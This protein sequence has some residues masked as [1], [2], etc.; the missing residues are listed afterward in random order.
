MSNSTHS[1]S[2]RRTTDANP[3]E[4]ESDC[5]K[6]LNLAAYKF[7][8]LDNLHERRRQLRRMA[9]DLKLCGTILITPEGINLF[10]AGERE[11]AECFLE[12]LRSEACFVDLSVKKSWTSFQPFRRM[13]VKIKREIIA[14]GIDSVRPEQKTSPKLS[15]E[16][17]K[18]WLDA[19][20]E[21]TLLDTRNDYEVEIG[22]FQGAL[23][24]GL[25]HFRDF[26]DAAQSLPN[27]TKEKPMVMFCTG[28]IRCEKAG[29]Y[30]EQAGF[31]NVFQ[32][33]GGILNYFERC[34]SAHY[35]G[36]CFVFDH[37][38]AVT[39]ELKP[40]GA[41]LCFVC[42]ATLTAE[43]IASDKYQP[44]VSC[45]K[46]FT[47]KDEQEQESLF[48]RRQA[49]ARI[50]ENMPGSTPYENRRP[51]F[52][53][54]QYA[55]Y[56][57]IDWLLAMHPGHAREFWMRAIQANELMTGPHYST[58]SSLVNES[59]IVSEGQ[60]IAHVQKNYVEPDVDGRIELLYEDRWLIAVNKPSTL[61]CHASG[62]YCRNTL[63]YLLNQVYRPEKLLLAHRLDAQTSGVVVLS[64]RY[65]VA[66]KLQQ[67]F[68]DAT[69]QKTYF[70]RVHGF[71]N[72]DR[73]TCD[74]KIGTEPTVFGGRAIDEAGDEAFTEFFVRERFADGTS[75]LEIHPRTGRTHQIRLHLKHLGLP[76]VHDPLYGIDSSLD[77]NNNRAS[78]KTMRLHAWTLSL[79]H[80]V[81]QDPMQF[82]AS[83]PNWAYHSSVVKPSS[84]SIQ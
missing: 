7:V 22:T 45:P 6:F 61:P 57:M 56:A 64:R 25:R 79:K 52:V 47:T 83:L 2:R 43:D 11:Q 5:R 19:G 62:Q 48:R 72:E 4:S 63:E 28:G 76:I 26:P 65:A 33:D 82:E 74:T 40:S 42:Q 68:A 67:Q 50:A 18:A 20:Q 9:D 38:V 77:E 81:S 24:L 31:K 15:P 1:E 71:P 23:D 73:F 39:P 66:G 36:D 16:Q 53:S 29:A 41:K 69:V 3:S 10:I 32:L 37:R 21:L 27:E 51:M 14:F 35:D 13:L 34:G 55:G 78:K 58:A 17:L 75:L 30:L 44:S 59:T 54:R 49:L 46:C 70:A 80:P 12:H 60:A 8:A 84:A